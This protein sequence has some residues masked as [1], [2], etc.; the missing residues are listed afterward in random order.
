MLFAWHVLL[1]RL[2]SRKPKNGEDCLLKKNVT[3]H[4][5][6]NMSNRNH[7]K[8]VATWLPC[9]WSIIKI[10]RFHQLCLKYLNSKAELWTT[11]GLIKHFFPWFS[12][13]PAALTFLLTFLNV[14]FSISFAKLSSSTRPVNTDIPQIWVPHLSFAH[15]MF[16]Y[17]IVLFHPWFQ[18]IFEHLW[19]STD[20]L[21][22]LRAYV[23]DHLPDFSS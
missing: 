19:L 13:P 4:K 11:L 20:L 6:L 9:E 15:Y 7:K 1:L 12:W 10:L 16:F 5:P 23:L 14:T 2:W 8:P 3:R 22:L 18:W 21:P 17:K